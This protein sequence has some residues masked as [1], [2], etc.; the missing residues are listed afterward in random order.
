MTWCAMVSAL[1]MEAKN[2]RQASRMAP[3]LRASGKTWMRL[4]F[5]YLEAREA[6]SEGKGHDTGSNSSG[7]VPFSVALPQDRLQ[8]QSFYNL[9]GFRL[10]PKTVVTSTSRWRLSGGSSSPWTV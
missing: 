9:P 10:S 7:S 5:T 1:E 3:P 4:T 8:P 2:W 6:K